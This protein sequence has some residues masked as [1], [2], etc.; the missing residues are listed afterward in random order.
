MSIRARAVRVHQVSERTTF[1]GERSFLEDVRKYGQSQRPRLVLDC[2]KLQRLDSATLRLLLC[3]LEEVMK[4]NGDVRLASLCPEAKAALQTA[5][6]DQLFEAYSTA[7][8]AV[9]SF[10]L[11]SNSMALCLTKDEDAGHL[12]ERAA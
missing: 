8:A 9:N 7:E 5:G 12:S 2:S 4:C 11:R 1:S 10:H 3:C 6:V